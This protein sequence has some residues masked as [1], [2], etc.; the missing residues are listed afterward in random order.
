MRNV[1][2][3]RGSEQQSS[4]YSQMDGQHD[5]HN[6]RILLLR[7]VLVGVLSVTGLLYGLGVYYGLSSAQ[8]DYAGKEFKL[9]A[10]Q[11]GQDIRKSFTKSS[12]T[13]NHLAERY[14]TTFPD[15]A[16]WPTVLLPGFN[17]DLHYLRDISGFEELVFLPLVRPADVDRTERFL[18]DAWAADPLIPKRA[19]KAPIPGIYGVNK[20]SDSSDEAFYK[21]TSKVDWDNEYDVILPI[22]Q[23]NFDRYLPKTWLGR[24]VHTHAYL[25]RELEDVMRCTLAS[26]YS[27]ARESCSRITLSLDESP[28]LP[29]GTATSNI[30][31][32]IMLRENRYTPIKPY[33]SMLLTPIKPYSSMLLTPTPY[34]NPIM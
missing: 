27:Y 26:N 14:A 1:F 10:A 16:E 2:C 32:P 8:R 20:S 24:A 25:G 9:L 28:L 4:G 33:S 22:A 29:G 17:R 19:Y 7:S 11:A 30:A 15:E 18:M 31:V 13:L 23:M 6:E 3:V 5:M 34:L 21:D 12:L